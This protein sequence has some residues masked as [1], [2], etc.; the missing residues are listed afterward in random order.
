MSTPQKILNEFW[1][2]Y[3]KNTPKRLKLCDA[4]CFYQGFVAILASIY[5]FVFGSFPF[6]AFLSAVF[7]C[8]GSFVLT[9]SLRMQS[10]PANAAQ[11]KGISKQ[12]AFSHFSLCMV[13]LLLVCVHFMG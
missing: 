13:V 10:N 4:F 8:L 5:C 3:N 2:N 6:N 11:F 9:V 7:A 12:T 1:G